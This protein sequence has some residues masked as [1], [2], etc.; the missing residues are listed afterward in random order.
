M[1]ACAAPSP[2][3]DKLFSTAALTPGAIHRPDALVADAG[4]KGLNV[5]R[6]AHALGA[7]VLAV[8]LVAGHAGQWIAGRL[9]A[10]GVPAELVWGEGETRTSLSVAAEGALTEFYERGEPPGAHAWEA[11]AARVAA[12]A[13]DAAWVAV[14]GSLPPGVDR[15][16]AGRLVAAARAAGARVAVDQH[17]AWLASALGAAPALVKVNAAEA[18]EL[19]GESAPLAAAS[20]LRERLTAA[21]TA[22][23]V[24]A[25]TLGERG[26]LL[27]AGDEAL[28]GGIALRAPYPVGS[29]DAFLAGLL[30]R[31]PAPGGSWLAAFSL[32]LGAG[33]ANAE[34]PGAGRLD[35]DRAR[36][37][38][39]QVV[40]SPRLGSAR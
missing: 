6:A 29:G 32:A 23:P 2:S 25:V 15:A 22:D 26:A 31:A 33:A 27:L 14:S 39:A 16:E 3:I 4:G 21:G 19:T 20:A 7:D 1:I 11:F 30:A 10:A 24:V 17:G 8:A 37:L 38:A 36:A 12:V 28:E 35:P 13:T 18:E 9:E 40:L 5:A 34:L